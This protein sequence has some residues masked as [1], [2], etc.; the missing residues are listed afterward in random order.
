[1]ELLE[2]VLSLVAL[3]VL[4]IVLGIDN[5]VFLSILTEKL[6]KKQRKNARRWGL[7]FAW[8]TRLLLLASAVWVVKL[9]QP[10]FTIIGFSFSC[11]DLFLMGGGVFLIAKATQEIHY[12]VGESDIRALPTSNNK[13]I[14][15]KGVVLQV[16]LMDIIFSFDSVLTAIGLTTRFLVMATAITCAILIMLYAS[17]PVSRF[18]GKHPTVKMLA[19]S[20]LILIGMVLVA[21]SFSFH[22]PRGYVY[23]AMGFSLGVETLNLLKLKRSRQHKRKRQG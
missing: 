20:F 9:T 3:T 19:L 14:T 21:D 16:A 2:I 18:I 4:E 5:L 7:T 23:F 6:P 11:R 1:M 17:E 13:R 8:M 10:L 12:E 22:V 15:F